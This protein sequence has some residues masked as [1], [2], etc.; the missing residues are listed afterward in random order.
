MIDIIYIKLEKFMS[1]IKDYTK[2]M[3]KCKK[4]IKEDK[5]EKS[6]KKIS[7]I[8]NKLSGKKIGKEYA[9]KIYDKYKNESVEWTYDKYFYKPKK[10]IS[11]IE[12]N[13]QIAK[14]ASSYL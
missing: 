8:D 5:P 11:K 3:E 9:I 14:D 12:K 13:Y 6:I 10:Y 7:N 1:Y 4:I 2:L